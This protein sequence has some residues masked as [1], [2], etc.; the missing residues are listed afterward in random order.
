M[1]VPTGCTL[2]NEPERILNATAEGRFETVETFVDENHCHRSLLKCRECG[3]LYFFEFYEEIDWAGGNDPQ[4]CTYIP[5]DT[6][7]EISALKKTDRW[8]ILMFA[9]RLQKDW[10]RDAEK[11]KV[12]WIGKKE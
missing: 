10:P 11:P 2:W 12:Y 3:Q 8:G 1:K 9:P 7:E 4:Y 5:V 6:H